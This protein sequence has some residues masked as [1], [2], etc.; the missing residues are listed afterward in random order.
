MSLHIIY[1]QELQINPAEK[2]THVSIWKSRKASTDIKLKKTNK[3]HYRYVDINAMNDVSLSDMKFH[4]LS[5][6]QLHL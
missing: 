5:F 3:P 4:L 6:I 2:K 1:Q